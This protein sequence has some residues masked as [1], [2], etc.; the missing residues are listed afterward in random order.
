M[1]YKKIKIKIILK[2]SK[3]KNYLNIIKFV[4]Y[5]SNNF[6][7]KLYFILKIFMIK[8]FISKKLNNI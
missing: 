5:K 2:K 7:F 4:N 6:S 8:F 1:K 3:I